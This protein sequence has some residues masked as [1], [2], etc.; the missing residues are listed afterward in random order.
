[1]ESDEASHVKTKYSAIFSALEAYEQTC[2]NTWGAN[3]S[4]ETHANLQKSLYAREKDLLRVNFDPKVV[5]L[6]REVKYFA[7]LSVQPP[8]A[9]VEIYSKGETFRKYIYALDNIAVQSN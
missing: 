4:F 6:L 1:M 5:A 2:F 8:E 9:A 7:A 3:I